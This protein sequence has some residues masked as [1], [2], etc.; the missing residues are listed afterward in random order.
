M[1]KLKNI[2]IIAPSSPQAKLDKKQICDFLKKLGYKATFSPSTALSERF[3]AGPDAKRAKDVTDAFL[4]PNVDVIL[5][6]RGG[7][8]SI[9]FLNLL[10]YALIKKNKKP[11]FGFSDATGLQLAL[12]QKAGLKSFTGFLASSISLKKAPILFNSFAQCLSGNDFH[13][14]GLKPLSKIKTK[15]TA[16]FVGGNLT[17]LCSLLGTP[18]FPNLKGKILFLEDTHEEPYRLDRLITQLKLAAIFEKT[19]GIVIGTFEDGIGKDPADGTIMDVIHE[20]FSNLKIPVVMNFNYGH[21]DD[22]LVIP[23]GENATLDPAKG[24]LLIQN[25]IMNY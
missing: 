14:T 25:T 1:K 24:T 21:H 2:R 11:F 9:R 3:M 5:A 17:L 10:D 23:M 8:G 19:A 13:I 16:P 6:M 12:Y 4:D 15:I 7:Y 22:H 20:Q 18:Y